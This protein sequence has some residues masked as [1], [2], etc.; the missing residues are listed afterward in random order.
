[1]MYTVWT[2]YTCLFSFTS[3]SNPGKAYTEPTLLFTL[4]LGYRSVPV[5][6]RNSTKT[7]E[8]K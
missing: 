5:C 7:V 2:V 4:W 1:M 3:F 8:T 6:W